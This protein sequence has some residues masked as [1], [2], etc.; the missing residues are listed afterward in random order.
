MT[1]AHS[2]YQQKQDI[3]VQNGNGIYQKLLHRIFC[4]EDLLMWYKIRVGIFQLEFYTMT[5]WSWRFQAD[6][7]LCEDHPTTLTSSSVSSPTWPS[8][9]L[10]L[11][12][13]SFHNR[14]P[15]P[16]LFCH[17]PYSHI[18]SPTASRL[19]RTPSWCFRYS[20]TLA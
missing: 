11:P 10:W 13:A 15:S 7:V 6:L 19:Q 20:Q 17:F 12:H 1:T 9:S 4:T 2:N 8:P 14:P 5:C 3:L 18:V 16:E